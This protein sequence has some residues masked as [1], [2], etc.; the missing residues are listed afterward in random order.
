MTI[1][2]IT[3]LL[4]TT[5]LVVA[6]PV[7]PVHPEADI[8]QVRSAPAQWLAA[9]STSS[10]AL[11]DPHGWY[12]RTIAAEAVA[13]GVKVLQLAVAHL[14]DAERHETR[15]FTRHTLEGGIERIRPL[16]LA[17]SS[18]TWAAPTWSV[19]VEAD[20]RVVAHAGILY[21]V[22]QV[23]QLRVP[24]GGLAGV[25]TLHDWRGRGY[26][27][28]ALAH[29]TAFVAMQLWARFA[30]VIC[31]RE[32]TAFYEHLGWRVAEAPISCEQPGG[33]VT[34]E[35]EVVL[36]LACQ[37]EADWPGGPINLMGTPW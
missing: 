5:R 22:I 9:V 26:A 15:A 33:Q 32:D 4:D 20:G 10:A 3:E 12:Q 29:A 35:G 1:D 31:P 25:M 16:A 19:L 8:Q 6:P 2:G 34:L 18:Y 17:A 11:A 27:R 21:R 14:S 13:S 24:V 7:E 28:A 30:V 23:G 37:G 36:S